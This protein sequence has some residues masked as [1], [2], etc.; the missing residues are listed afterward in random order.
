MSFLGMFPM[1]SL[2]AGVVAD[3]LGAPLTLALG[4]GCCIGVGLVL[5]TR[6][7]AL[8]SHIRAHYLRL[9]IIRE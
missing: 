6:L 9:G 1:G 8:R 7:A 2:A 5:W 4:G 3:W